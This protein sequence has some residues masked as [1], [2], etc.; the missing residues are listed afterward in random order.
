MKKYMSVIFSLQ[1]FC[2]LLL[3]L[4]AYLDNG[5]TQLAYCF[6]IFSSP[7]LILSSGKMVLLDEMI[8]WNAVLLFTMESF[9]SVLFVWTTIYGMQKGSADGRGFGFLLAAYCMAALFAI[10]ACVCTWRKCQA[11]E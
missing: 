10:S 9:L 8:N 4:S 7:F 6:T 5:L 3:F 1:F 2:F 11:D